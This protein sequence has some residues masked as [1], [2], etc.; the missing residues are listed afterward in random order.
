MT[1]R[2]AL[3]ADGKLQAFWTEMIEKE[4]TS[5]AVWLKKHEKLMEQRLERDYKKDRVSTPDLVARIRE[6]RGPACP[7]PIQHSKKSFVTVYKKIEESELERKLAEFNMKKPEETVKKGLY[8]G[9]R[10][11]T[12]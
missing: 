2:G 4:S 6:L 8:Q 3:L 11:D 12:A 9:L 1:S 10:I 7:R 5:R